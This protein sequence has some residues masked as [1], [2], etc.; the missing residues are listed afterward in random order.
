MIKHMSPQDR[1]RLLSRLRCIVGRR[2]VLTQGISTRH[3]CTGYRFGGGPVLAV[4]RPG[5]L[6]EQWQVVQALIQAGC[7][8]IMQAANT[9]LTGGS[10]P[11]GDGYD[12]DI[13]LISTTRLNIV[14]IIQQGRQVICLPG[15]TLTQLEERL[16][17]LGREPHSVI[18]S[19]CI[20][21]SVFGGIANNSGGALVQRGPAYTELALFAR[22]ES[23]G[24]LVL[25]NRLGIALGDDPETILHRLETEQYG[26]GDIEP[27]AGP[28]SDHGYDQHVRDIHSDLPARFNADP[29]R[30][31]DVSG[32]AG[33]LIMFAVRLDTFVLQRDTRV[34]YIGTNRPQTLTNLRIA[35]LTRL[36][37][38]PIAA[39]YM[40]RDAYAM[41][42][43]YGKDTF[44][45][46]RLF[47][48]RR[49]KTLFRLKSLADQAARILGMSPRNVADRLLQWIS[50]LFPN[51]LPRRL[52]QFHERY[53]HHLM[54]KVSAD[55]SAAVQVLLDS[56]L[57]AATEADDEAYFECTTAEA[58]KAFLHRFAA[59]GAVVRYCTIMGSK[60]GG[61][62]ALD[63]ALRRN[64]REWFEQ[65]PPNLDAMIDKK[66]YYGHFLCHVLHQDYVL[67]PG[68]DPHAVE[69]R[70]LGEL[71]K[72]GARYPAEHGFG[73]LYA[74]PASLV[75]FYQTLDPCN[76]FNPGIGQTSKFQQWSAGA[77]P[78]S[79]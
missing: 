25:V 41:A 22:V 15:A 44:L 10:T 75:E 56:V 39:E 60:T 38:L 18:G 11:D 63:I 73:H 30:L 74:A 2:Y 34:F 4:V 68:H 53:D 20:G 79:F 61:M 8:I 35:L 42:A 19:S 65:L 49:M 57:G 76:C 40:H 33:K 47:G 26:P 54:L 36:Q 7:I 17:P 70:M 16:R 28:A 58:E 69:Q 67:R 66:I 13:V 48:A 46:I 21:A 14:Q 55:N 29:S 24:T 50:H 5:S 9:G 6:V 27:D 64:D 3:Y 45:A 23:N 1:V 12:R 52:N 32:C 51:H 62:V 59:A 71:D 78:P 37:E 72:R 77:E 31:R 43:T